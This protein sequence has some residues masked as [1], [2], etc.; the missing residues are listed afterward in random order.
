[1]PGIGSTGLYIDAKDNHYAATVVGR[2]FKMQPVWRDSA[3]N[4]IGVGT[5]P[6]GTAIPPGATSKE[7]AVESGNF[8]IVGTFRDGTT[9]L[10][11]EIPAAALFEPD[12]TAP[13]APSTPAP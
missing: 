9:K 11:S 2:S 10:F 8:E 13:A 3:G 4:K 1:M 5:P 7:E 12:A 6:P